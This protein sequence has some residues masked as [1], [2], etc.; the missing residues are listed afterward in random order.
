MPNQAP[1]PVAMLVTMWSDTPPLDA[2]TFTCFTFELATILA[3]PAQPDNADIAPIPDSK[4]LH[5]LRTKGLTVFINI[6]PEGED[7]S[8]QRV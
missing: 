1:Y 4:P 3:Q 2:R 7:Y 5:A 6:N 8:F